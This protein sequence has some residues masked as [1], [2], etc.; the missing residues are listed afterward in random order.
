MKV[1]L[2]KRSRNLG[3]TVIQAAFPKYRGQAELREFPKEGLQGFDASSWFISVDL[4]TL[5]TNP[6]NLSDI[7]KLSRNIMKGYALVY[8]CPPS[9]L[10]GFKL[11]K[12]PS[13]VAMYVVSADY[14]RIV[15]DI[16][17]QS[18]DEQQ[19]HEKRINNILWFLAGAASI[20]VIVASISWRDALYILLIISILSIIGGLWW[21][22]VLLYAKFF[23]N[24]GGDGDY[25]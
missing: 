12:K 20:F 6:L 10:Y 8:G 15:A 9:T 13:F 18:A 22:C 24:G 7:Q 11:G 1:P 17:V 16:P 25:Y 5:N 3:K 2:D 21:G 4:E 14:Q 23:G 19:Q